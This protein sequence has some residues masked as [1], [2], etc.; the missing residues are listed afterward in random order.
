MEKIERIVIGC[1]DR[2]MNLKPLD[3]SYNDGRTLFLRNAGCNVNGLR[4]NILEIIDNRD[5]EI[6][7]IVA[8]PH[9]NCKAM[10]VVKRALDGEKVSDEIMAGLVRF[11]T[12]V[13]T[14]TDIDKEN[15][16]I[17]KAALEEIV[18]GSGIKTEVRFI[19]EEEMSDVSRSG[20]NEVLF[21]KPSSRKYSSF[22]GDPNATYVLQARSIEDVRHDIEIARVYLRISNIV[23]GS[24]GMMDARDAKTVSDALKIRGVAARYKVF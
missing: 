23:V 16:N 8:L 18:K 9:Q 22:I 15:Y 4:D 10:L 2:K 3:D 13:R 21:L 7:S 5:N 6:K 12:Q 1:M 20:A 11:Y 14:N 24:I 19:M 17:Q